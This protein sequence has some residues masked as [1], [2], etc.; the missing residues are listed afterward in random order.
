MF[1]DDRGGTCM[2]PVRVVGFLLKQRLDAVCS[3]PR[4]LNL[5]RRI[6]LPP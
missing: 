4:F 1:R 2:I 3:D 6:G 5:L